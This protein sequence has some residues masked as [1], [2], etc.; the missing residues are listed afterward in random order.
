MTFV[1]CFLKPKAVTQNLRDNTSSNNSKNISTQTSPFTV[2]HPFIPS[3]E[4]NLHVINYS[5]PKREQHL[6]LPSREGL[7]CVTSVHSF[8]KPKAVT[9]NLRDNTSSNNSK[10][11]STQTSSLTVTHPF[12]P[13]QEGKHH[14]QSTHYQQET[15]ISNLPSREGPGVCDIRAQLPKIKSNHPKPRNTSS[16][17]SSKINSSQPAHLTITHPFN[18]LSRGES[19]RHKSLITNKKHP[20]DIHVSIRIGT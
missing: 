12:I 5:L 14:T 7:G 20:S 8:L 18:P 1:H 19:P 16:P 2:T 11:I 17:N 15:S 6:N 10:S 3:Q 13:S 4:G 9:Q